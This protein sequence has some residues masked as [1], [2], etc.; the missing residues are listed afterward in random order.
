MDYGNVTADPD[1]P[2]PGDR[3]YNTTDGVWKYVPLVPD[4]P[5]NTGAGDVPTIVQQITELQENNT[6]IQEFTQNQTFV[7]EIT[8]L[9]TQLTELNQNN[10]Y[11]TNIVNQINAVING[12]KGIPDGIASVDGDGYVSDALVNPNLRVAVVQFMIDGAGVVPSQGV[13]GDML[14]PFSGVIT[15]WTLLGETTGSAVVNL[16]KT[17]YANYPAT[18]ANKITGSLPPTIS[19]SNK[20]QSSTLTGWTTTVA[21][22][23]LIRVNVDSATSITRLILVLEILRDV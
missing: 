10:T 11:V 3:W 20:G 18:V 7:T 12:K 5:Y 14:I 15:K 19:S 22:G 9:I 13:K 23:D 17:S 16:W 1:N 2:Q 8:Q 4:G 6:Y 21:A